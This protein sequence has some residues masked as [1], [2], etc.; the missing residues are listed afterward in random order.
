MFTLIAAAFST[1]KGAAIALAAVNAVALAAA[2]ACLFFAHR[3][4]KNEKKD[5][6]RQSSVELSK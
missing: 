4:Q 2:L 3:S 6:T 1:L 5:K